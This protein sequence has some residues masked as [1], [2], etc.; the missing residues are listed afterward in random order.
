MIKLLFGKVRTLDG[1]VR[2]VARFVQRIAGAYTIP[3]TLF[4]H[5]N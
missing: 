2:V 5:E 1:K 4:H 3:V